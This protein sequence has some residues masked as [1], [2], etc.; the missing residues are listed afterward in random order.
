MRDRRRLLLLLPAIWLVALLAL[1][2]VLWLGG[3]RQPLLESRA[4]EPFPP[5]DRHTFADPAAIRRLDTALLDRLPGRG[6]ALDLHARIALDLFHDSPSPDVSIGEQEWLY[7]VPELT[8]CRPGGG[9]TSDPAD[10]VDVLART[11]VASGRRTA[12]SMPR[13]K[14]FIRSADAPVVDAK[15]EECADAM[16]R[17]I[18]Q[19]LER[20]PGGLPLAA[21]QEALEARGEPTF[22]KTDTHWNW[23]GRELFARAVLNR[24]RPN[25]A[26]ASEL[27]VGRTITRPT[28]LNAMIGRSEQEQD[29]AVEALR[30]PPDP[31]P[32]G[33][34]VLIGDSQLDF[35]FIDPRGGTRPIR[36]VAL[37]GA[38]YCNWGMLF[39]GTCNEA[40]SRSRAIVI[41]KVMREVQLMTTQCWL[42][43][44]LV[45][46][47][48][49]AGAV[50]RWERVDGG[51]QPTGALTLPADGRATVRV[52]AAGADRDRV[53][54]LLRFRLDQLP[55]GADGLPTPVALAQEPQGGEQPAPCAMPRQGAPDGSLFLPIPAGARASDFVVALSGAPG[56]VIARP[57]VYRLDG[58]ALVG[59]KPPSAT[60]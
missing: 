60:G 49:P 22:L 31:L 37:P 33:D 40:I 44:A 57:E 8:P 51:A 16:E 20:T 10:A 18:E 25:L 55:I 35:T 19:R 42:P 34:V 59:A 38:V 28:D 13:S 26:A 6:R 24:I 1:P 46:E 50:G 43:I 39:N 11:L 32:A 36:D 58:R 30:T 17:R 9:P 41:E 53:P 15:L 48:L 54:R 7:Y 4:K 52:Q 45:G 29:R 2:A 56:S 14:L 23:R 12:I 3:E 27:G 5:L 21:A 47:Q